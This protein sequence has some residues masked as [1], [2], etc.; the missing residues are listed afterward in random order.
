MKI[1]TDF[2]TNS[3]SSSFIV[4]LEFITDVETNVKKSLC[5]SDGGCSSNGEWVT[6]SYISLNPSFGDMTTA[7]DIDALCDL[8]FE[9]MILEGYEQD[10]DYCTDKRFAITGR[11]SNYEREELIEY[12]ED[13]DGIVTQSVSS[14][15]DYL[16][17]NDKNSTS[18]KNKK[19]KE[20]GIPIISEIEFMQIFDR[21]R[22]EDWKFDENIDDEEQSIS[23]SQAMP[24]TVV[25][26]KQECKTKGI[27]IE[28]LHYIFVKN[29]RIGSGDSAMWIDGKN[30]DFKKFKECYRTA[31]EQE[32][33]TIFKEMVDFV[34]SEPELEV[35]DNEYELPP[36]MKCI[37]NGKEQYLYEVLKAYLEDEKD[38]YWLGTHSKICKY[39]FKEKKIVYSKDVLEW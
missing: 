23:V 22:F 3:S 15:T 34:K 12:I 26:F 21:E 1:R 10:E 28:N 38:G 24:K 8:L 7:N 14:K 31:T 39:D 13:Q 11:L 9:E 30:S 25:D 18:S 17:N 19:A 6:S 35:C 29:S 37:W 2:V 36:K 16:I 33:E 5:V 4:D 27:T 20:L 32:K